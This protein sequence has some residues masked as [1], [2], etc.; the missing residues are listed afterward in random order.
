[1]KLIQNQRGSILII[2]MLLS[3]LASSLVILLFDK[4]ILLQKM[5]QNS[6][7]DLKNKSII[8]QRIYAQEQSIYSNFNIIRGEQIQFRQ[9]VPDTLEFGETQGQVYYQIHEKSLDLKNYPFG[10]ESM[11]SVRHSLIDNMAG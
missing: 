3:L 10:I 1:M 4:A 2:V 7:N 5:N 8:E 11:V 9:F 6:L